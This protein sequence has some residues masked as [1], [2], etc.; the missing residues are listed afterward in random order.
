VEV[1][2]IFIKYGSCHLD[3]STILSFGHLILLRNIR[4]QKLMLDALLLECS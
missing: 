4:G 1:E 3:E 2:A